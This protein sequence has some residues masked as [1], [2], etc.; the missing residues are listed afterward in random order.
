MSCIKSIIMLVFYFKIFNYSLFLIG[1]E[2]KLSLQTCF[3][4]K[5]YL[6]TVFIFDILSSGQGNLQENNCEK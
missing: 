5:I 2:M 3:S 1:N 4:H 6:L